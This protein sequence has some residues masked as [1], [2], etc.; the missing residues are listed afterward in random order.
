MLPGPTIIRECP[1]CS[2]LIRQCSLAS[3]NTFG[4][5]YWTDGK[6]EAPGCPDLPRVVKCPDCGEVFWFFDAVQVGEIPSP[7]KAALKRRESNETDVDEEEAYPS[8]RDPKLP[9]EEEYVAF[10]GA[11]GVDREKEL[12]ARVWAWWISNDL[13]REGGTNSDS[14][15]ALSQE[16]IENLEALAALL[17]D[18]DAN[19]RIMKAEIARE[20]GRFEAA[21]ALIEAEFPPQFADAIATIRSLCAGRD[22]VV[23]EI[24]H[25]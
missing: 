25:D 10:A 16:R 11:P 9:S 21:E 23:K 13:V 19:Q 17:E 18:R 4:A 8:A 15:T 12:Y 2:Q 20:L 1:H 5:R 7:L 24:P 3:S 6:Q 14:L 22:R